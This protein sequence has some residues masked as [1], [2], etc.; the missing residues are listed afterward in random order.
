MPVKVNQE[1][2]RADILVSREATDKPPV[3]EDMLAKPDHMVDNKDH[4]V[5]NKDHMGRNTLAEE[6]VS[7]CPC[8]VLVTHRLIQQ[9]M[10]HHS[11]V[12]PTFPW[13]PPFTVVVVVPSQHPCPTLAPRTEVLARLT[14]AWDHHTEAVA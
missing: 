7:Q 10:E 5:G 6:R 8:P 1:H 4:T 11:T 9:A 14:E 3:M 2:T 13:L 12:N